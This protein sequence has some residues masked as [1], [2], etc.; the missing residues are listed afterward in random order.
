M[1][2]SSSICSFDFNFQNLSSDVSVQ[3]KQDSPKSSSIIISRS[4]G[5]VDSIK[6]QIEN[7]TINFSWNKKEPNNEKVRIVLEGA[8]GTQVLVNLQIN[9]K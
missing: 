1:S 7:C 2:E 3:V 5:C 4:M 8:I 9:A 6:N